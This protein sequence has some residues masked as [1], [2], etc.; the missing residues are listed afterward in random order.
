[1]P[2][3]P[4]NEEGSPAEELAESATEEQEE[5]GETS[6]EGVKVPEEFQ[7]KCHELISDCDDMACVD[8]LSNQLNEKRTELYKKEEPKS[9]K[10]KTPQKFSKAD[11]PST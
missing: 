3:K 2:S 9:D 11:M 6:Q 8:Y 1:M 7:K 10:G 5:D 4:K